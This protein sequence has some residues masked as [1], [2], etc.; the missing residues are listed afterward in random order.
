MSSCFVWVS[1][2]R[3]EPSYELSN[4]DPWVPFVPESDR[5]WRH[6]SETVSLRAWS[7]HKE[8]ARG[9]Y[10]STTTQRDIALGFTGWVREPDEAPLSLSVAETLLHLCLGEDTKNHPKRWA[11]KVSSDRDISTTALS[12]LHKRPGQ[13]A[14]GCVDRAGTLYALS[15]AFCGQHLYYAVNR[16]NK[17]DE[18]IVSNRASLVAAYLQRGAPP[19]PRIAS[20]A[21]HLSRHESPLGDAHSAWEGVYLIFP[22][23]RLEAIGGTHRLC[24]V[25]LPKKSERSWDHLF[26]DLIW[27]AGQ[28]KRLPDVQFMLPLTG[29]LDSR[30]IFGALSKAQALSSVK[31]FYLNASRDHA[32]TRAAQQIADSYGFELV[33]HEPQELQEDA[34]PFLSRV[35][36][37]NFYVEY[38][39]NAWDLKTPSRDLSCPEYGVLPGHY[40]ELYRSHALPVLSW[41]TK[42]LKTIYQT[43]LYMNRHGLLTP[44]AIKSCVDSGKRWLRGREAQNTPANHLLDELHREARMWR[45]VSQ[46]QMFESLGYPSICLL[47]DVELRARYAALPLRERLSPRVHFELLR[48]VDERLWSLPFAEHQWP[49]RFFKNLQCVHTQQP[50][51]HKAT[52]ACS[53]GGNELN[54]QMQMWRHQQKEIIDSLLS[55]PTDHVFWSMISRLALEKKIQKTTRAPTTQSVKALLCAAAFKIALDEPLQPTQMRRT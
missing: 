33:V 23:Q 24:E 55:T 3:G 25:E 47:A 53:G 9:G 16:G 36:R 52:P 35:R 22:E 49:P 20:L 17:D 7:T 29:G 13:F 26:S 46:T 44:Q 10:F 45:W 34:E 2:K 27:R 12:K 50:I 21:W 5:S 39:V 32:D 18:V 19:A 51:T 6:Q 38:M 40:G 41:N 30:L 43:R 8:A 37:H 4:L 54:Y 15:D 14:L 31:C 1:H 48:R 42:L 11:H 28:L